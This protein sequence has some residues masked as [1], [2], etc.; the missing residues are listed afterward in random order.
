[1]LTVQHKIC[2]FFLYCLKNISYYTIMIMPLLVI[3]CYLLTNKF[4]FFEIFLSFKYIWNKSWNEYDIVFIFNTQYLSISKLG[5]VV[6]IIGTGT[7]NQVSATNHKPSGCRLKLSMK[8]AYWWY[9]ISPLGIMSL[10]ILIIISHI[11]PKKS[12]KKECF[13]YSIN[14][15]VPS[16]FKLYRKWE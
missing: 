3:N 9:K 11:Y 15:F 13:M 10:S 1:M 8:T 12:C 5:Q 2:L 16:F 6:K 4:D 7:D 14:N